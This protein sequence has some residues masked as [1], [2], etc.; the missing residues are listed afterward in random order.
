M[1]HISTKKKQ[2][3]NSLK[4]THSSYIMTT[5]HFHFYD[6]CVKKLWLIQFVCMGVCVN[7]NYKCTLYVAAKRVCYLIIWF[8]FQQT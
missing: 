5:L 6:T 8:F 3:K 1:G 2:Q 7:L 4:V